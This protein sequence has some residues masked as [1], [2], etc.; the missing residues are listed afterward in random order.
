MLPFSELFPATI[1]RPSLFTSWTPYHG[2]V[3]GWRLPLSCVCQCKWSPLSRSAD[4]A[5][6]ICFC[7]R[8]SPLKVSRVGG[9]ND[10]WAKI[11]AG[12]MGGYVNGKSS[13][14]VSFVHY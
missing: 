11:S 12:L 14:S 5:F 7:R 4:I 6:F 13:V 1:S 2:M 8:I 9:T 3:G 10:T